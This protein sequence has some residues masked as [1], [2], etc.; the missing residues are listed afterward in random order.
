[1]IE[2]DSRDKKGPT[3]IISIP[4][5][6]VLEHLK[7]EDSDLN[8]SVYEKE[9]SDGDFSKCVMFSWPRSLRGANGARMRRTGN[10][11]KK[12]LP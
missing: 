2:F 11:Q 5:Q 9:Y 3:S 7:T 10:A 1:M 4:N 12:N 6:F 8:E